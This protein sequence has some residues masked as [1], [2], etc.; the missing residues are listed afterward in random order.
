LR[1][2]VVFFCYSRKSGNECVFLSI[3]RK[4]RFS[5]YLEYLSDHLLI[6]FLYAF[7]DQ[8]RVVLARYRHMYMCLTIFLFF[9]IIICNVVSLYDLVVGL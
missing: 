5:L 9:I 2:M 1:D 8:V 7:L 3:L 6:G 4:L